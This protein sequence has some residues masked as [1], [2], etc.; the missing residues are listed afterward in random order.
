MIS[1][2]PLRGN[3]LDNVIGAS[4]NEE[5]WWM[6]GTNKHV[7]TICRKQSGWGQALRRLREKSGLSQQDVADMVGVDRAA[8]SLWESE[9]SYPSAENLRKALAVMGVDPR[10]LFQYF[11]LP[12]IGEKAPATLNAQL[13]PEAVA[14]ELA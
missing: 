9:K 8:I 12:E 1:A 7:E 4:G 10:V 5:G 11:G 2:K 3:G 13:S 6:K 14:R